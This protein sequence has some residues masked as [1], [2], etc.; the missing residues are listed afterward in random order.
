MPLTAPSLMEKAVRHPLEPGRACYLLVII[1]LLLSL[2]SP[3]AAAS[4]DPKFVLQ[5]VRSLLKNKPGLPLDVR[6]QATQLERYYARDDAKI[7]WLR[8]ERN[9]ELESALAGLTTIGV[10]NMDAALARINIRKQALNSDDTSILALVELTY[11]ATLVEARTEPAPR[12]NASLSGSTPSPHIATIHLW[13]S[14]A[15]TRRNRR[16]HH[17]DVDPSGAANRR[18]SGDPGKTGS[19]RVG[20]KEGRLACDLTGARS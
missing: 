10:T 13:R 18:L 16:T 7:L 9:S 1:L 12:P 6:T 3:I 19:I 5:D 14:R 20:R 4:P 17:P 2:A 11:S 15:V 8:S